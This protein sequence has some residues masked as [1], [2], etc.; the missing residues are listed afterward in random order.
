L[1]PQGYSAN[2]PVPKQFSYELKAG[3]LIPGILITGI[4]SDLPGN[5]LVQVSENV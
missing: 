1:T 5:V 3:T 4:N 2:L